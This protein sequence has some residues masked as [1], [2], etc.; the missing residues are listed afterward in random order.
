MSLVHLPFVRQTRHDGRR[1]W[2][3]DLLVR[4]AASV[5]AS[6][7]FEGK[8]FLYL[9]RIWA[10]EIEPYTPTIAP[11]VPRKIDAGTASRL[12]TRRKNEAKLAYFKLNIQTPCPPRGAVPVNQGCNRSLFHCKHPDRFRSWMRLSRLWWRY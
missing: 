6:Q 5:G 7:Q 3:H 4:P 12:R 11:G 10:A 2:H 8:S 9:W 1:E